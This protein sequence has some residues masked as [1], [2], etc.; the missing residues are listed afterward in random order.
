MTY[1]VPFSL[2]LPPDEKATSLGFILK[3]ELDIPDDTY[4]FQEWYCPNPDCDCYE[5]LLKVFAHQQKSITAHVFVPLDPAQSP[6][7]NP[8]YPLTPHRLSLAKF[9][10]PVREERFPLPQAPA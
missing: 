3:D 4:Q 1:L 6:Y 9:D 8:D 7:L 2:A 5:G 10:R